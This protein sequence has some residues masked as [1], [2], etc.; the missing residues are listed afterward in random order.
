MK[1]PSRKRLKMYFDSVNGKVF[2][3]LM[4]G[5]SHERQA[6]DQGTKGLAGQARTPAGN[7]VWEGIMAS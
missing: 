4:A 6:T 7:A 2:E 3:A 1:I 5:S